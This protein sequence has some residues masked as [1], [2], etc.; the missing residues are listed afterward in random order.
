[1]RPETRRRRRGARGSMGLTLLELL[2]AVALMLI[3]M[4]TISFAFNNAS[5]T[6]R[7]AQALV[8]VHRTAKS[9][10]DHMGRNLECTFNLLANARSVT[11]MKTSALGA[12]VQPLPGET[13]AEW[14]ARIAAAPDTERASWAANASPD[15]NAAWPHQWQSWSNFKGESTSITMMT[16]QR[17]NA[18]LQDRRDD[19]HG[20]TTS[21]TSPNTGYTETVL[22]DPHLLGTQELR[23]LTTDYAEVTYWL[24]SGAIWIR[25]NN[26]YVDSMIGNALTPA[27]TPKPGGLWVLVGPVWCGNGDDFR[28]TAV[29][30]RRVLLKTRDERAWENIVG[31]KLEYRPD[32]ADTWLP[33]WV[34]FGDANSNNQYDAGEP[35]YCA[36]HHP[37][38]SVG[39]ND[40]PLRG[41][42]V[43]TGGHGP[44][45]GWWGVPRA[46]RVTLDVSDGRGV[47]EKRRFVQV[48]GV[49]TGGSFP[50]WTG[51]FKDEG[52]SDW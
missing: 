12:I 7:R 20:K 47:I 16:A 38:L 24:Q 22:K 42:G 45:G 28:D 17:E 2:V 9:V 11:T 21:W 3:L 43:G 10:F 29:K 27:P 37:G 30:R 39:Y 35:R 46:V 40:E 4:L 32:G 34:S 49:T 1:M 31:L 25:T 18:Y 13:T 41:P 19:F 44:A 8:E 48:L 51:S 6:M 15:G 5:Q 52:G 26:N 23:S 50:V 33:D 36:R 14:L